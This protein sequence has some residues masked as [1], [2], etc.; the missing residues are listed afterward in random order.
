MSEMLLEGDMQCCLP[1]S[2]ALRRTLYLLGALGTTDFWGSRQNDFLGPYLLKVTYLLKG[3]RHICTKFS[4]Y[5]IWGKTTIIQTL[6]QLNILVR[7][8]SFCLG[9]CVL[10]LKTVYHMLK[11]FHDYRMMHDQMV[12]MLSA[13][14]YLCFFSVLLFYRK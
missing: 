7:M 9:M 6:L 2:V 12:I 14:I 13:I 10:L 3:T 8:V 11:L 4:Y 5:Y 1:V